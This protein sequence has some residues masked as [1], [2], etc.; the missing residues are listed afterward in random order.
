MSFVCGELCVCVL[1]HLPSLF[2]LLYMATRHWKWYWCPHCASRPTDSAL[3][4][5]PTPGPLYPDGPPRGSMQM[6]QSWKDTT[7]TLFFFYCFF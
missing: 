4:T 1:A 5:G 3:E 6:V 2:P 7:E